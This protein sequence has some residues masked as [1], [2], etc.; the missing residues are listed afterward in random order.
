MSAAD[1]NGDGALD[2][3]ASNILVGQSTSIFFNTGG[4]RVSL[5]SSENPSHAGDP[6]TFTATLRPTFVSSGIPSGTVTFFDGS[7]IL[8]TGALHGRKATLTTS[9]LAV[10]K[11][12]IT[13]NYSGDNTFVPSHSKRLAEKV[14]AGD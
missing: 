9:T 3:A 13:A 8:G 11:H 4:N 12:Q 1:L 2:I 10:G 7:N 6:V 14:T 5:T